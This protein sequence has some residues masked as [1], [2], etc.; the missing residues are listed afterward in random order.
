MELNTIRGKV[1]ALADGSLEAGIAALS[2]RT[3]IPTGTLK[4][5]LYG[6]LRLTAERGDAVAEALGLSMPDI[7]TML[8]TDARYLLN[9]T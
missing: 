7:E 3:G 4:P 1:R 5:A 9:R 8:T 6:H 2:E